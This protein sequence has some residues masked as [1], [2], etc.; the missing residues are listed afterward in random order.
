[1]TEEVA[2]KLLKNPRKINKTNL[3]IKRTPIFN[4]FR[5]IKMLHK[6]RKLKIH[7]SLKV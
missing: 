6:S 5:R 2:V 4:G 3:R 7:F 1:M